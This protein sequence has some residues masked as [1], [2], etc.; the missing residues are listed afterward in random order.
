MTNIIGQDH[1]NDA[2][3]VGSRLLLQ[4]ER[5]VMIATF[6]DRLH[7]QDI[8]MTDNG[9]GVVSN[10]EVSPASASRVESLVEQVRQAWQ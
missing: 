3:M 9:F 4:V 1:E 5:Y 8:I 7:S 2:T 10:G 6:L